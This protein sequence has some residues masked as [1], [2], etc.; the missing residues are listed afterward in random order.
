MP[1]EGAGNEE[2]I[3]NGGVN[4]GI[5]PI[6]ELLEHKK[7]SQDVGVVQFVSNKCLRGEGVRV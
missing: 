6:V 5:F 1:G 3:N 7:S 4:C 2:R